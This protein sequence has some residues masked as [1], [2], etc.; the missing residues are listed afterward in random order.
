MH[1]RDVN[2]TVPSSVQPTTN[3]DRD[4]TNNTGKD[5]VEEDIVIHRYE[6]EKRGPNIQGINKTDKKATPGQQIVI[7][8][9][10]EDE[11]V[12]FS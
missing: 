5:T 1:K 7:H 3:A 8:A 4:V 9:H 10:E 6:D 12:P 11:I 2:T